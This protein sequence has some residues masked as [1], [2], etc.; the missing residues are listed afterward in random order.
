VNGHLVRHYDAKYAGDAEAPAADVAPRAG[1]PTDRYAA[2]L[3]AFGAHFRGGS[4]LEVGAGQGRL[5]RALLASGLPIDAYTATELSPVRLEALRRQLR[6]PR[7]RVEPLDVESVPEDSAGGYDAVVLVALIEHLVDPLRAMQQVRRLLRPG[8]FAW[9]DTPNVAKWTRRLKLLLGRFPSTASH[10][11]GLRT[12][13]GGPVDLHDEG[14]LHY[15]T[16]RSLARMLTER[17]GFSRVSRV[18]YATGPHLVGARLGHA[19]ARLRPELFA[20]VCLVAY[21]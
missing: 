10:D 11:E 8:G 4:V 1:V 12:F 6:D 14:H 21:A 18:P 3:D 15:F 20:E 19:L 16:Y 5:A 2:C 7:V 17:C 13:E 9:V